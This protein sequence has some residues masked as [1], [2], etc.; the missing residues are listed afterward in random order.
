MSVARRESKGECALQAGGGGRMRPCESLS[1]ASVLPLSHWQDFTRKG[2]WS[3][4]RV[5]SVSPFSLFVSEH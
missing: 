1:R 4:I 5:Y 3:D 2:I